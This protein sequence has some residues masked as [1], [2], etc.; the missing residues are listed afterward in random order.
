MRKTSS[1]NIYMVTVQGEPCSKAN[2]R[3]V[4]HNRGSIRVI[5]SK[6]ALLYIK[7]FD[8]QCPIRDQLLEDDVAVGIKIYYKTRRPDLDESIILDCL[9]NKVYIND[10]Q[11]KKKYISHGLDKENPR[12]HI[13]VGDLSEIQTIIEMV[14][15]V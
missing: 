14:E 15:A 5:K 8:I 4:V 1:N 7:A 12:A 11:V 2:S 6:K 13:F 3:R 10:R 9:Q